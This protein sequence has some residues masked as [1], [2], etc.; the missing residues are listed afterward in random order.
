MTVSATIFVSGRVQGVAFRAFTVEEARGLGL[1]GFCRNLPDGR[2][3]VF[4]EGERTVIETL[5]EKLKTGPRL[6]EV[7][8]VRVNWG[9][10]SGEKKPFIIR[11]D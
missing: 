5:I 9:E 10:D 11:Y 2:V 7:D 3:E 8:A 1:S 6:A 4:A